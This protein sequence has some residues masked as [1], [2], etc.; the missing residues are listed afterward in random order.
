[1]TIIITTLNKK[2]K[3][4]II[5]LG[6]NQNILAAA[7]GT[8]KACIDTASQR[9]GKNRMKVADIFIALLKREMIRSELENFVET[10][11]DHG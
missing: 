3:A 6:S 1:M 10:E 5:A 8:A 11:K 4:K 9:D 2:N 7:V